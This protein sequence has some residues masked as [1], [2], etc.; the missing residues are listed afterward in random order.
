MFGI[1]FSATSDKI[2]LDIHSQRELWSQLATY[3]HNLITTTKKTE[4]MEQAWNFSR[5][6]KTQLEELANGYTFYHQGNK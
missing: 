1:E 3:S 2:H 4:N 5:C 6:D